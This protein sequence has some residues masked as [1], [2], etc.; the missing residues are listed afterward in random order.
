MFIV[1]SVTIAGAIMSYTRERAQRGEFSARHKV[2]LQQGELHR[3]RRYLED[4]ILERTRDLQEANRQ[5]SATM[6][7]LE[8]REATIENQLHERTA[9][10]Q[11]IHHRVGNNLQTIGSLLELE[12]S[13]GGTSGPESLRKMVARVRSMATVHSILYESGD[14][15]TVDLRRVVEALAQTRRH[16]HLPPHGPREIRVGA[17]DLTLPLEQAV[18][19]ALLVNELLDIA[20]TEAVEDSIAIAMARQTD[21]LVSVSVTGLRWDAQT[22]S[23]ECDDVL[24]NHLIDALTCQ[25]GGTIGCSDESERVT[26]ILPLAVKAL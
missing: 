14:F 13:M 21:G 8:E 11:E 10:L 19:M 15:A 2:A 4:R 20:C 3:H 5:L 18:P 22:E 25:V 6:E 9:M 26:L 1:T 23:V 12:R 16:E 24:S 7:S 17:T